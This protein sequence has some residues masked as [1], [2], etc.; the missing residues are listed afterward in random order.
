MSCCQRRCLV[1]RLTSSVNGH[2][3]CQWCCRRPARRSRRLR[4]ARGFGAD[5]RKTV[6][7]GQKETSAWLDAPARRSRRSSRATIGSGACL[8][9]TSFRRGRFCGTRTLTPSMWVSASNVAQG[10]ASWLSARPWTFPD[11]RARSP[12]SGGG[13]ANTSTRR[14]ADAPLLSGAV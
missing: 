2:I 4:M 8:C 6:R 10:T 11:T 3:T 1:L 7:S 14:Y 12:C 9:K 5:S 13:A